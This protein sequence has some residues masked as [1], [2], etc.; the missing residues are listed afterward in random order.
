M[1]TWPPPE[2]PGKG[3]HL[4]SVPSG[5]R[6]QRVSRSPPRPSLPPVRPLTSVPPAWPRSPAAVEAGAGPGGHHTK[7]L[8]RASAPALAMRALLG[9]HAT[10]WMASSCFL[11]WAV[12]SCTHVLLSRLHRRREQSWP[13][14]VWEQRALSPSRYPGFPEPP[15]LEE[16]QQWGGG[17]HP[18]V[19]H[20]CRPPPDAQPKG[21]CFYPSWPSTH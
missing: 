21:E 4:R 14:R 12:I 7:T 3:I 20:L 1:G 17:L 5:V 13:A 10:A 11:R 6:T 15:P 9:W 8:A 16:P 19:P 18:L 2:V